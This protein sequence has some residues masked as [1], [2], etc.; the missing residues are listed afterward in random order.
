MG[1]SK[2][3][4]FLDLWNDPELKP[5]IENQIGKYLLS[6]AGKS[7]IS[8][9]FYSML[10]N[11]RLLKRVG[12]LEAYTG[13]DIDSH[14]VGADWE[15]E[16]MN[17][18]EREMYP[19]NKKIVVQPLNAQLSLLSERINDA[20]I[21]ILKETVFSG[22][23]TEIRARFLKDHLSEVDMRNGKRFLT[24]Q[25]VQKYLLHEITEAHRTTEKAARKVA[26]DVM[27]KAFEMFPESLILTKNKRRLNV[28]EFLGK[29]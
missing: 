28:I 6:D 11:T 27:R 12:L 1:S 10:G 17:S 4:Q 20:S 19:E 2:E 18:L 24:S 15:W 5:V 29:R 26:N 9:V 22:N 3:K 13:L 8:D 23:E 7:I 14:S 16:E 21:P 25:E